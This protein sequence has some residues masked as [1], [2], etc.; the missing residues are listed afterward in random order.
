MKALIQLCFQ[1][2]VI[3]ASAQLVKKYNISRKSFRMV[4]LWLEKI[5]LMC[6]MTL[7]LHPSASRFECLFEDTNYAAL[8]FSQGRLN[9]FPK[10]EIRSSL[11]H[12]LWIINHSKWILVRKQQLENII[13]AFFKSEFF[14]RISVS[15]MSTKIHPHT[16]MDNDHHQKCKLFTIHDY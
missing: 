8:I 7:L 14:Y 10:K 6:F 11:K 13:K 9:E 3:T 2:Q 5:S 4:N 16:M 12:F 1:I 15:I